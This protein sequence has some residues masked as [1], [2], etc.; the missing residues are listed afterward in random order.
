MR[1]IQNVFVP[2]VESAKANFVMESL[3]TTQKPIAV[4]GDGAC[5]KSSMIK[6]F[7]FNQMYLFTSQ[8]FT[9][10]VT[11]SHY[12]TS[13]IFKENIERNLVPIYVR[14]KVELNS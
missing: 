13:D 12:T 7:I 6:D 3:L 11:C 1:L 4:V 2:T 9:D 5:G 8:T 10:H 14:K